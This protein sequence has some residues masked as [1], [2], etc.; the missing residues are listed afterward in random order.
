MKIKS[1]SNSR[2][3]EESL[4][5]QSDA[6][7]DL[8]MDHI[9]IDYLDYAWTWLFV[10]VNASIQWLLGFIVLRIRFIHILFSIFVKRRSI[11]YTLTFFFAV[12]VLLYE[13][14]I[15]GPI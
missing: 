6:A 13:K 14:L 9:A 10:G 15:S 7:E 2:L 12:F 3:D 5:L 11:R 4:N 8:D 1:L